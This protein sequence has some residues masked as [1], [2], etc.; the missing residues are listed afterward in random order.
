LGVGFWVGIG[1]GFGV[2]VS[3]GAVVGVSVGIAW[4]IAAVVAVG[5]GVCVDVGPMVLL[6]YAEAA[7][8]QRSRAAIIVPHPRPIFVL[9][10]RVLNQCL[11]P[12]G[13][14]GD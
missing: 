8:I 10:E 5:V 14:F 7:Q 3:V 9:R 4:L 2:G 11:K 13:G 6:P 1:V 12:D